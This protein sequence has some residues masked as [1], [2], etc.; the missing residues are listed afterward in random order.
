MVIACGDIVR[1]E[2]MHLVNLAF[3]G[4]FGIPIAGLG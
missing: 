1:S 3:K 4:V 2:K